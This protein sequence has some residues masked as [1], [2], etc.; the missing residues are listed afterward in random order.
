MLNTN[1]VFWQRFTCVSPNAIFQAVDKAV[2]YIQVQ[3]ADPIKSIISIRI[4]NPNIIEILKSS[5]DI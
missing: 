1:H 2:I 4:T 5:I 3:I